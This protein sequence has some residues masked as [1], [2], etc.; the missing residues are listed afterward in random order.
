MNRSTHRTPGASP[1][2]AARLRL[3]R[4]LAAAATL[5]AATAAQAESLS[6]LF[7]GNSYTFGRV[8]PVMSYNFDNV[9]DLTEAMF[10]TNPAGSN[11]FE[12]R[13]WGGV[14]GIFERLSSQ[15]G[16][17]VD[18]AMSTR[19]AATLRGH[20]LNTNPAGWDLRGN[21]A[22]QTWD[23]VVLQA[24]SAEPLTTPGAPGANPAYFDNYIKKFQA[25]VQVGDAHSYRERD[26][27]PGATTAEQTAA[28]QAA[29]GASATACNT[30]RNIPANPNASAATQVVLYQT[31]AR[32]NIIDGAFVTTT[33]PVTGAV[34]RTTTLATTFYADLETMTE[35]LRV[36]Y[37]AAA[38]FAGGIAGISPVGEAFL[39]AVQAGVATRDMYAPNALTDGLIDLW[40]DDGTHASKWGSYLSALTLFGSLTGLNPQMFGAGE[41]A[42]ME[43]GISAADALVLQHVAAAQLG[44]TTP[45]P[46]PASM[47]LALFGLGVVGVAARRRLPRSCASTPRPAAPT[48]A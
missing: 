28:C 14:P 36:G 13:P 47:M 42:A 15:A 38:S 4:G 45:I 43:L 9:R 3:L 7:V 1:Q 29:T 31:W 11:L 48:A 41:L 21:V 35:E 20:F 34:T 19:N 22:S 17:G 30:L 40:F 6:I 23:I 12:P 44:F 46:E 25:F 24:Q 37:N 26:F 18:V 16:L 8:D 32:P 2:P 33:D 10:N 5:L 27:F 39:A